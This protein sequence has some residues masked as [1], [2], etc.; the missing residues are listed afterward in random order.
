MKREEIRELEDPTV[1][2]DNVAE[3]TWNG[4]PN[5]LC[6]CCP[7]ASLDRDELM[8]HLRVFHVAPVMA[9]R[10]QSTAGVG[11]FDAHDKPITGE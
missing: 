6:P 3:G 4:L 5:Y 8:E 7:H 2:Y 10:V 1:L 11:L 9:E